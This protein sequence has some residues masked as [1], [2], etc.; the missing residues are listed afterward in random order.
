MTTIGTGRCE[1]I[2]DCCGLGMSWPRCL[3]APGLA[4]G[5]CRD[6]KVESGHDESE[7]D[8]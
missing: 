1:A 3:E 5:V 2:L 8:E 4:A 6:G 7:H